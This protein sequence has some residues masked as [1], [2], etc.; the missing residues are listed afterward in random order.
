MVKLYVIPVEKSCNAHCN[1][2]ITTVRKNSGILCEE[3]YLNIATLE[4]RLKQIEAH[5]IEITGGGEPT[6]HPEIEKIIDICT[7]QA[8]TQMYT[9]G[10]LAFQITNLEK[11][12][13]LCIS[14]AHHLEET[15]HR[16]MGIAYDAKQLTKRLP[17]K[18]SLMLC[19]EGISRPSEFFSY[20]KWASSLNAKKVVVREMFNVDYG[21]Q[22][23]QYVPIVD[24]F[25]SLEIKN[26]TFS[27]R[28]P[29]Y[30]KNELEIEFEFPELTLH[31]DGKL[32]RGWRD[33]I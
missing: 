2:C 30:K 12:D 26:Y 22:N 10:S 27:G 17:V 29:L 19:N 16:I 6:L 21:N 4:T 7:A 28:N 24:F 14:R 23:S 11:L 1:F 20:L 3:D 31:A 33:E 25:S 15:N 9:N 32:R 5:K 8:K 13:L 18:F